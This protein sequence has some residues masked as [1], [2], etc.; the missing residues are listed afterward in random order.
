MSK[1]KVYLVRGKNGEYAQGTKIC[2]S[3]TGAKNSLNSYVNG[4]IDYTIR[5]DYPGLDNPM[6]SLSYLYRWY[7]SKKDSPLESWNKLQP[8]LQ[9]THLNLARITEQDY[10]K[11]IQII[12][13]AY[14]YWY[15]EE[16]EQ[17]A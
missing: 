10:D 3:R 1:E 4:I 15:V 9:N 13:D 14:D 5:T 11:F 17:N 6:D 16:V 8:F 7:L 12:T 2:A